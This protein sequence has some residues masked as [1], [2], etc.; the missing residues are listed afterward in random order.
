MNKDLKKLLASLS[1]AGLLGMGGAA[2]P[3]G[4]AGAASG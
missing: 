3:G 2:L 1:V 4:H